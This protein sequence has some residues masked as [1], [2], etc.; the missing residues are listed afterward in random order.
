MTSKWHFLKHGKSRFVYCERCGIQIWVY[1][2]CYAK[3]CGNAYKHT[4]YYCVDCYE[5]LWFE[6]KKEVDANAKKQKKENESA[7]SRNLG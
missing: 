5:R 3:H 6:P 1:K 7:F 4:V 2:P